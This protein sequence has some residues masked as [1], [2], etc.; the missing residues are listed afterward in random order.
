V[1]CGEVARQEKNSFRWEQYWPRPLAELRAGVC[2]Q[3]TSGGVPCVGCREELA[4]ERLV[5]YSKV[6]RELR[7]KAEVQ[8]YIV[9]TAR[10][11]GSERRVKFKGWR[12]YLKSCII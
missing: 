1:R 4:A 8:Q 9:D 2:R 5:C 6:D 12:K 11:I 10:D 7:K 3:C